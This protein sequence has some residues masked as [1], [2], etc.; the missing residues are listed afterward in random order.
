MC[1]RVVSKDYFSIVYCPE[2]YK[3]Q[4][5]CDEA[6]DGS[7]AAPKLIPDWFVT[8]KMIKLF[9]ALYA[10]ENILYFLMKIL[11]MSYFL[12]MNGLFLI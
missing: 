2:K 10:D 9:A 4:R 1:D 5:M 8:G 11:I 3:A 7:L 6:V 12:V